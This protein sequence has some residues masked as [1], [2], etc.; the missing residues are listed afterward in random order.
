MNDSRH[1]K[2]RCDFK[3]L[4]A[5]KGMATDLSALALASKAS[6]GYDDEFMRQCIDALTYTEDMIASDDWLFFVARASAGALLGF[7]AL[8]ALDQTEASLE[9]L[10]VAP[11]CMGQ[12]VGGAL[13]RHAVQRS[14]AL[15]KTALV[16]HSEPF[17]EPFYR[18]HGARVCGQVPSESIPGRVLPLMRVDLAGQSRT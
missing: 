16:L 18:H 11:G 4:P 1:Q 10:F 5:A 7:Y 6:W 14:A 12:G 3:I 9:A 8:A 17:A 2:E 13:M 15:G